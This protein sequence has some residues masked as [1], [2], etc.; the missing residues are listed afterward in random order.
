MP[1][2]RTIKESSPIA[3][4]RHDPPSPKQNVVSRASGRINRIYARCKKPRDTQLVQSLVDRI[5]KTRIDPKKYTELSLNHFDILQAIKT[6]T[7][8]V[9]EK[10]R[11]G[12]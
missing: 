12:F 3:A 9:S 6:G 8:R 1:V 10:S 5:D 7:Y 4:D 11:K 2:C